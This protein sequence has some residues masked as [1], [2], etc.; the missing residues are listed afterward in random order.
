MRIPDFDK[1][2]R[3]F[4]IDTSLAAILVLLLFGLPVKSSVQTFIAFS[5]IIGVYLVPHLFSRGQTFG[6]RVQKI[7]IINYNGTQASLLKIILRDA[8]KI[9]LSIL[10]GGIYL[11]ICFFVVDEKGDKRTIH[12]YIFRTIVVDLDKTKKYKDEYLSRPSSLRNRG[13]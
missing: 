11:I 8:F 5:I 4:S 6:K 7:Q 3:A 12:D 2:I 13:L 1:R 9:S 10:T